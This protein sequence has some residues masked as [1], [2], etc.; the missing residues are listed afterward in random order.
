M[1]FLVA[2]GLSFEAAAAHLGKQGTPYLESMLVLDRC[3]E[4]DWLAST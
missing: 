1:I 4:V 2:V 3:M